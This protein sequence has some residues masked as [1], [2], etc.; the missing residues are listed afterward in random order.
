[1]KSPESVKLALDTGGLEDL[2]REYAGSASRGDRILLVGE[3]GSGKSTFARAY[4]RALGVTGSIPSPSFI[5]D[6]VY[7]ARGFEVHHLDLY[8]LEGC[9]AE[10][11]MLGLEDVMET[12]DVVLVE[13]AD[14]L[15]GFAGIS[16][17]VIRLETGED[18]G[19]RE[20]RIDDRRMAGD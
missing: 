13:W 17:V 5:M 16:G 18:P 10:L 11:E 2:A 9:E 4:L 15:P 12:A 1:M 6:A 14:R 7:R 3:L 8:R 19:V 20:V